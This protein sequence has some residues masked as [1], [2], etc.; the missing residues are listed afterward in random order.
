M[1]RKVHNPGRRAKD[2]ERKRE[3]LALAAA[4]ATTLAA[5]VGVSDPRGGAG[6]AYAATIT[7]DG[8][9][10]ASWSTPANWSGNNEPGLGDDV[11]FPGVVPGTG[12][13]I[14]LSTGELASILVFNNNYTLSGGSLELGGGLITVQG[15]AEAIIS[16]DL[17]GSFTLF[18]NGTGSLTLT[19]NNTY[20]GGTTIQG[21]LISVSS[22]NNL[23]NSSGALT[24]NSGTLATTGSFSTARNASLNLVGGTFNTSGLTTLTA[25]GVISGTS[26]LTKSGAGFLLLSAPA[27]PAIGT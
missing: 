26:A 1:R 21:G 27:F 14:A 19:G 17:V 10:D 3:P 11:I 8:S 15:S 22:D 6:S 20:T 13:T 16:S 9:S 4:A 23:G 24:F 25:S 12:S 18:R 2:C 5:I 7:W